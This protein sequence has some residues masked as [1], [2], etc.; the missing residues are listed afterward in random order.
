MAHVRTFTPGETLTRPCMRMQLSREKGFG[1]SGK[2]RM[3]STLDAGYLYLGE[4]RRLWK[5]HKK[6][7][8]CKTYLS[9]TKRVVVLLSATDIFLSIWSI[10][11]GT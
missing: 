4:N 11:S 5:A 3:A 2:V 10:T 1:V 6:G 8:Q 9:R 7:G